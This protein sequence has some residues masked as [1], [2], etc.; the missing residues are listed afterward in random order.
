MSLEAGHKLAHYEIVAPI[1][2]GGMGEV[3]QATDI[4]LGRDVAIKVL[5]EA[6]AEDE[7]RLRRMMASRNRFSARLSTSVLLRSLRTDA[8]SPTLQTNPEMTRFT[9]KRSPVPGPRLP[10]L[11]MEATSRC[12][13]EMGVSCS[14]ETGKRFGRTP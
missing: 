7:E 12:G 8:I 9:S 6:F 2:K 5:P 14:S 11:A 3:Y 13:P 1:G 4:K 10:Y